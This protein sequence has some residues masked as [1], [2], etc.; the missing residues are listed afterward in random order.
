[1]PYQPTDESFSRNASNLCPPRKLLQRDGQSGVIDKVS[2]EP[3]GERSEACRYH[4]GDRTSHVAEEQQG[5]GPLALISD[6]SRREE[7]DV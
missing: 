6:V 5:K 2:P 7:L 3:S 1:M 4:C